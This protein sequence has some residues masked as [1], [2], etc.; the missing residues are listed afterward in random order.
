MRRRKK[1]HLTTSWC[2]LQGLEEEERIH[3]LGMAGGDLAGEDVLSWI[4]FPGEEEVMT[5]WFD[6]APHLHISPLTGTR[7]G[8]AG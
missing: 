5:W 2:Y 1:R 7:I 8:H 3:A 4:A 6:L